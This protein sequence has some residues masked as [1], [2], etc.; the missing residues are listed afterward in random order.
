MYCLQK[1]KKHSQFIGS[2]MS[3]I[4]AF[5]AQMHVCY[6]IMT[7]TETPAQIQ[8][9]KYI[10]LLVHT[11]IYIFIS[12]LTYL[13]TP[14]YCHVSLLTFTYLLIYVLSLISLIPRYLRIDLLSYR[15]NAWYLPKFL[16]HHTLIYSHLSPLVRVKFQDIR[17][18]RKS[19][20]WSP[21]TLQMR[22]VGIFI[23]L[24]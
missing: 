23:S 9:V 20:N 11:S 10:Y 12:L 6:N 16:L 2:Q 24:K 21:P 18:R 15:V 1:M 3:Y 5:V 8:C 17:E 22:N 4:K 14:T 19:V 7:I 13:L